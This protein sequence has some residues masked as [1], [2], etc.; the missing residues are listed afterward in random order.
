MDRP[1]QEIQPELGA[2][3]NVSMPPAT[4]HPAGGPSHSCHMYYRQWGIRVAR[5]LISMDAR[6]RHWSVSACEK[7][8]RQGLSWGFSLASRLPTA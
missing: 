1:L 2:R 8:S 6:R 3:A 4:R 5:T 7:P